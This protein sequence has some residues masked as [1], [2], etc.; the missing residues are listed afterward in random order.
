[1]LIKKTVE[2]FIGQS[3]SDA[4]TPGGGGIAALAGSLGAAMASMAANFTVGRKKFVDVEEEVKAILG[5]LAPLIASLRDAVDG[6]A[7]AFA[8]IS[9]A[10]K[11]PKE[12]E[13]E[14]NVRRE[15]INAALTAAMQVPAKV[16]DDCLAAASL[17][18]RL[19]QVANPNLLSDV[20][21]AAVMLEAAGRAARINVLVNSS[22]LG[23][24]AGAVE[25]DTLRKTQQTRQLMDEALAEVA[26]RR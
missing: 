5:R 24:A 14:K 12:S 16:V 21:V 22:Q 17:L 1:M 20:E 26:K 8:T 13:A 2:E 23:A 18:P 7:V 4:P 10:F 6:D 9:D 19:A 15:A 3:A 11:L 25:I